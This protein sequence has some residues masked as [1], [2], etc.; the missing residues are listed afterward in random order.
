MS[1]SSSL[2]L[3]FKVRERNGFIAPGKQ[4]ISHNIQLNN[5]LSAIPHDLVGQLEIQIILFAPAAMIAT[6]IR[7]GFP[8]LMSSERKKVEDFIIDQW[9]LYGEQTPLETQRPLLIIDRFLERL[10]PLLFQFYQ[11]HAVLDLD[12]IAITTSL[13][14]YHP[15]TTQQTS[16]SPI[17]PYDQNSSN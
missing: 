13:N 7:T 9:F 17:R 8:L 11:N 15:Q 16:I 4:F 6:D 14:P 12:S 1:C 5:L 2:L 10:E 3:S